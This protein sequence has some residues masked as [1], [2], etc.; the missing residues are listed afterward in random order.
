MLGIANMRQP[1]VSPASLPVPS[2][3]LS[4]PAARTSPRR[5]SRPTSSASRSTG[6]ASFS[7]PAATERPRRVTPLL[8]TS[9]QPRLLRTSLPA[10]PL[11]CPSRTSSLS[12]RAPS[13]TTRVR[14]THTASSVTPAP[15]P[16]SS[17]SVRSAPRPRLMRPT[18]RR[19]KLL[20]E[21]WFVSLLQCLMR[22]SK[23]KLTIWSWE[24][25]AWVAS[26]VRS[27]HM[28]ACE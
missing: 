4:T 18:P 8:R 24:I 1:P 14:R 26:T 28:T 15:R 5:A 6:S 3:S 16:A 23:V 21:G 25:P 20:A 9:S 7:S 27:V 19:N 17:V 13:A 2:V 12:R 10:H 11:L 22:V